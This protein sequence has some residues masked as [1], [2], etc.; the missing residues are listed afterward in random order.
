MAVLNIK[1]FPDSLYKKLRAR[2]RR[3]HRSIAQEVTN[4]L[5]DALESSKP[6]SILDLQGLGKEHWKEIDASTH[7]ERE[8][9]SWD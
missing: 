9:T 6:L 8:R 7:I 2:A 3:Q 1:G 5:T 4:I